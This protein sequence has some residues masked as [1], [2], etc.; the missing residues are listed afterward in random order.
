MI[1]LKSKIT[2][3]VLGYFIFNSADELYINEMSRK[4]NCD[5][6][7]LTRK[8]I[9]LEKAGILKSEL[10]GKQRYFSLNKSFPL[11]PEYKK[12]ILETAG[13]EHLLKQSVD[14]IPDIDNA[15]IFGSYASGEIDTL[16]DIDLLVVGNHDTIKLQKEVAGMQKK[17]N[18]QI[19]VIS[20]SKDEYE[21][22][23]RSDPFLKEIIARKKIIIK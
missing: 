6:G 20:M 2:K 12:I 8:L 17:I 5:T 19:N 21:R 13:F 22:K 9:E 18:R 10:K 23:K 3:A 4:L 7:N 16:S 15:F 11:L 1:S 14:S